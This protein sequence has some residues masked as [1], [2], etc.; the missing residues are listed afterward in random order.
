MMKWLED[1][2]IN[3]QYLF[4]FYNK[5]SEFFKKTWLLELLVF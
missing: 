5:S 1:V 4:S 2:I 3:N